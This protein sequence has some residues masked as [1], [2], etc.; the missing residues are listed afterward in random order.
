M[1]SRHRKF[2]GFNLFFK[3]NNK[4]ITFLGKSYETNFRACKN[5]GGGGKLTVCK[6]HFERYTVPIGGVLNLVIPLSENKVAGNG[7]IV[8]FSFTGEAIGMTH[9]T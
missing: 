4:K 5:S 8:V 2:C 1:E 7:S 3:N 9:F 6:G